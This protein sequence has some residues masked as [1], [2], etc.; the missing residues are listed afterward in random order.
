MKGELLVCDGLNGTVKLYDLKTNNLIDVKTVGGCP[1]GVAL[2][3]SGYQVVVCDDGNVVR[4]CGSDIQV[5]A[6]RSGGCL[7]HFVAVATNDTLYIPNDA[8]NVVFV[9]SPDAQLQSITNFNGTF[10]NKPAGVKVDSNGRLILCDSMNNRV[11]IYSSDLTPLLDMGVKFKFNKPVALAVDRF[12]NI[13]VGEL[14]SKKVICFDDQGNHLR[15][16]M[17]ASE[18]SNKRLTALEVSPEELI[19]AVLR[20]DAGSNIVE[21]QIE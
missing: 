11:L 15:T 19:Y 9:V 18:T 6:E 3:E 7:Y 4:V 14:T 8:N 2:S 21:I 13:Y 12:D 1:S 16:F 10:L 5:V 20:D 17:V